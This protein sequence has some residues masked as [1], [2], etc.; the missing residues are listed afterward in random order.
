MN[1]FP[2][3][4]RA[5]TKQ[6]AIHI[7]RLYQGL[8]RTGEARIIG[9]RLLRSGTSVAA[10]Y[11]A[12]G[13]A[14]SRAEFVSKMGMVVEEADETVFWLELLL[15]TGIAAKPQLETL[16]AEAKELV[17]IF[18]AAYGTA[19]THLRQVDAA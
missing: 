4:M 7:V 8:P 17:A 14:R 10:N 18:A 19:R 3:Q 15:E 2:E 16:L 11:R 13:R 9:S 5:R 12:T 1:T 6:F